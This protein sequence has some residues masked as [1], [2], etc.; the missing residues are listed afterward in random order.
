MPKKRKPK[1]RLAVVDF[2]TDPFKFERKP[3]PFAAGF[4][5]GE[6]Y[7]E[8]WGD[9][10]AQQLVDYIASR[11]DPLVI[12]AHNGGKFDFFYFLDLGAIENP[13]LIIHG[14]ITKAKFLGI[15]EIRDSYS[16]MPL[17]LAKLG[18]QNNS[19]KEIDYEKL[20][21]H[22]REKHKVEILEYQKAD[23]LT[24]YDAVFAFRERFG[25]KLT[26]GAMAIAELKKFH[27]VYRQDKNHDTKFRPYYFGGRVEC[28]QKG[29]IKAP[30]DRKIQFFDVNS[31]YPYAM[32]NYDHPLGANYIDLGPDIKTKFNPR[33]GDIKGFG[34]MYFMHCTAWN[35]GAIP[36]RDIKTGGLNF[37]QEYGEF[38][39]CSH[40]IK[41][42]CELGLFKIDKVHSVKI[43]CDWQSYKEF[44]DDC[45]NEKII[46]KKNDDIVGEVFAKLR[47]NS[48][49]GKYASDPENFK[50]WFIFNE[51]EEDDEIA[52]FEKWIADHPKI[53]DENGK[54]ID[55]GAELVHDMGQYE[56]WQASSPSEDGYFDVA[57]AASITSA[58]RS[59]LLRAIHNS[60]YPIYCDTDSL[61]C[62]ELVNVLIDEFELGAWKFEGSTD[63][64]YVV[65]KK[66]YS[67]ILD[68]LDKKGIPKN[69]LA[70]KGARLKHADMIRLCKGEIVRWQNDAPNFKFTGETKY[71]AR[72]IRMN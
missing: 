6:I 32:K 72:N 39:A 23:C 41:V 13:A 59:I 61:T 43:P 31:M 40:E 38:Y 63:C 28:F 30:P 37:Y 51:C 34:G 62:F 4:Y 12:Y 20:E 19:K 18:N 53:V 66:L 48:A 50:D 69:K 10:A 55:Y 17:P 54:V 65:G 27:P 29:E 45:I 44:V 21:R 46:A 70:S 68:Q 22:C 52:T 33:T 9:D 11:T 60:E 5:D 42:A 58:A 36:I 15:H 67:A 47:A 56:I 24:L 8:F 14:R 25:P 57:I 64:I 3:E 71:V 7:L 49:Y 1:Y 16:I 2:E 26:V 35:K